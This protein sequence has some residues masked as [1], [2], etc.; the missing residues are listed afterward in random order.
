MVWSQCRV[1]A[2]PRLRWRHNINPTLLWCLVFDGNQRRLRNTCSLTIA[3]LHRQALSPEDPSVHPGK[4]DTLTWC[5]FN[6]GPALQTLNQH[7]VSVSSDCC[8]HW[9]NI[10][11][12]ATS[13]TSTRH[14]T[15]I[16]CTMCASS[17]PEM[18]RAGLPCS[19][20]RKT[21]GLVSDIIRLALPL[22]YL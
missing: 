14:W 8:V 7:W 12:W 9:A 6:V 17:V 2:G 13:A 20:F 5:W 11:F 15:N 19:V 3:I 1:I 10:G 4:H 22:I 21:H 18:T 16:G